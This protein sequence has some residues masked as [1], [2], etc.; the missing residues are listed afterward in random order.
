MSARALTGASETALAYERLAASARGE[1]LLSVPHLTPET[2]LR[3]TELRAHGLQTW[4]DLL[5][6]MTRRGLSLRMLVADTDP[7][8]APDRHRTAWSTASGFARGVE[9]NTQILCAPHG[10]E[11]TGLWHWRL[12]RGFAADLSALGQ[13]DPGRLTA[14]QRR[15]LEKGPVFRP[16]ETPQSFAVAD[17]AVCILGGPDLALTTHD[18]DFCGA[19]RAHFTDSW[20][21]AL[22]TG[23]QSLVAPATPM[24]MPRRPQSR[25]DLRLLRT[26]SR[27]AP[28]F[29]P[30]PVT[31]DIETALTRLF[32][33]AERHI[34]IR[35]PA[36]RHNGLTEA[37]SAAARRVPD[38]QLVLLLGQDNTWD[39]ARAGAL[40]SRALMTLRDAFG[41][42][43]AFRNA[44]GLATT[45]C[46]VDDRITVLG[47]AALTRRACRWNTECA[48]LARDPA[49]TRKFMDHVGRT[50]LGAEV[51][52]SDLRRADSWKIDDQPSL[53]A[54]APSRSRLPEDLF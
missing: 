54:R 13:D 5:G 46:L 27:P 19:L 49:L 29:G 12:R 7:V 42:R 10:Q 20:A 53:T 44:T 33:T 38:L 8:L 22:D 36:L 6:L 2:P 23:A 52:A 45:A 39:D 15:T 50:T 41:P 47:S 25:A 32:D 16:A 37:L 34:L 11:V 40:Q 21:A 35:T 4:A 18:A 48:V 51:A 24:R 9:G 28:G 43:L 30:R 3:I 14:I 1:L 31:T 17:G 26:L